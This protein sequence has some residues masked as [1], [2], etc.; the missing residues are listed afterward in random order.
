MGCAVGDVEV[1]GV[2]VVEK[3]GE[4]LG[5]DVVGSGEDDERTGAC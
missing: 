1:A 3:C 2:C 5:G 4:F